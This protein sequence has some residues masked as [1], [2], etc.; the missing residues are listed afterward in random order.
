MKNSTQYENQIKAVKQGIADLG[1]LH[2]GSLTLQTRSHG[3]Q[4]HHL[5][6]S[7]KGK[8]HTLYIRNKDVEQV[9]EEM[10]NYSKFK[11]LSDELISLEIEY[12]KCRRTQSKHQVPEK[13]SKNL[14]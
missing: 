4:Y 10:E 1:N 2:P 5:S 14:R 8:G 12:A 13:P 9:K 6:Y 3:G 11:E 7:H